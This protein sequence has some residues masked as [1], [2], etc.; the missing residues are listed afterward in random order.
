ML[1]RGS[2][3]DANTTSVVRHIIASI[4]RQRNRPDRYDEAV[5]RRSARGRVAGSARSPSAS[6]SKV[7]LTW[8]RKAEGVPRT[9][10][11]PSA[12]ADATGRGSPTDHRRVWGSGYA[13]EHAAPSCC[14]EVFS[15]MALRAGCSILTSATHGLRVRRLDEEFFGPERLQR[16][17]DGPP[18]IPA[19]EMF[20]DLNG[21]PYGLNESQKRREIP[22]NT[23]LTGG[24]NALAPWDP[25]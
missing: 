4:W 11:V 18:Q 23:C 17:F 14:Y 3:R 12:P 16:G 1:V 2:R 13:L 7:R 25:Q 8:F 5:G 9:K 10:N 22:K 19:S 15:S 20:L 6:R 21:A 24:A